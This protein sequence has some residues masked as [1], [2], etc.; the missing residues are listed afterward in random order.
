[1]KVS[2]ERDRVEDVRPR[3]RAQYLDHY[4]PDWRFWDGRTVAEV[5]AALEA[6]PWPSVTAADVA[7]VIGNDG[8]AGN[9]KC[10][11]CNGEFPI[12]IEVGQPPDYESHTAQLCRGCV[13]KALEM[14]D[15]SSQIGES[16]PR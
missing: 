3:W 10:H 15:R 8:W 7:R 11:E 14:I 16:E 13:A 12:I 5:W 2:T 4:G 9:Q 6:L 1:M